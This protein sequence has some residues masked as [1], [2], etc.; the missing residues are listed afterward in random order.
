[1]I[2]HPVTGEWSLDDR[3]RRSSEG[4]AARA[5]HAGTRLLKRLTTFWGLVSA[6]WFS[7]RWRE[8]W[9]LSVIVL[10]ITV[11]LSK[12]AVWTA[13]A[14]ADFIASLAEFHRPDVADPARVIL[15]SA[16]AFFG[17]AFSRSAG[18]AVRHLVSTT[19]HRRARHWLIA[20]FDA[21][22]L[23]DRRIA[24]DL[25]SDRGADGDTA[26]LPDSIDQRLD[27]CTDHLYGGTDRPRDG[28][29]R[30]GGCRSGSSRR[31]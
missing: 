13:T 19:L 1:M 20:R 6:Y 12:A 23:S 3:A 5:L 24:F 15:L 28:L 22:I 2:N 10:A 11:L 17:I 9:L 4:G 25:M 7:E 18:L 30:R 16:L 26:R 27:T 21:E 8:A 14:S 31:R 29:L